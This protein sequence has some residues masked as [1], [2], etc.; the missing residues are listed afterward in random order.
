MFFPVGSFPGAPR[1]ETRKAL[2]LIDLQNDFV[3]SN[4]KLHVKNVADFLPRLPGLVSKFRES[5]DVIWIQT[6]FMAPRPTIS[7]ELGS[8]TIVLKD[9]VAA[10]EDDNLDDQTPPVCDD[11]PLDVDA[12][13]GDPEA[14]LAPRSFDQTNIARCCIAGTSGS[15]LSESLASSIDDEKDVILIKSHYSAFTGSPFLLNLR[16]KFV[17]ELYLCGSLSNISVYATALDAV[18]HGLSV[19]IIEDCV[20]YRNEACHKEAMRQMADAMGAEGVELQELVDDLN[21]DLGDVVTEDT[22]PTRFEVRLSD[23]KRSS[24]G[25]QLS[26]KVKEWMS[27]VDTPPSTNDHPVI[28]SVENGSDRTTRT[29]LPSLERPSTPND[30]A[31]APNIGNQSQFATETLTTKAEALREGTPTSLSPPRKRST[32]L[33]FEQQESKAMY[34]SSRHRVPEEPVVPT[35]KH[36][37][38][39]TARVRVRRRKP[40]GEIAAPRAPEVSAPSAPF[41]ENGGGPGLGVSTGHNSTPP[42]DSIDDPAV[43]A[44]APIQT[45][46]MPS[47]DTAGATVLA[48][49][50]TEKDIP[51]TPQPATRASSLG[52]LQVGALESFVPENQH[53]GAIN[54]AT[55]SIGEG[56]SRICHNILSPQHATEAFHTLRSAVQWQKM[57]H[58]SGEVP[59]LVAVQGEIHQDGSIPIYRHPADESPQLRP[60]CPTVQKLREY[61]EDMLQHPVNHVLIQLYRSG[62]DNISEHSDKTLDI[63]RGSDIV[64]LSLG[65]QR[66]MV[67]RTKKSSESASTSS[68]QP[69]FAQRIPLPHNSLFILGQKT[70]QHWLHAIRADKRRAA[71]KSTEE[72]DF[73]GERISLTF[74]YVGTFIN[75]ADDTIWGQGASEKEKQMAKKILSGAEA[76]RAGEAMIRA[77]GLENH[78]SRGFDWDVNYGK[79]FDV[80]NFVTKT[81][82]GGVL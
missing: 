7:P 21:G 5:G 17:S 57:Y 34:A 8:Y 52:A 41:P 79:G 63:V 4:G 23:L 45:Q 51:A 36:Q 15:R 37:K 22:F 9:F 27:D 26:P 48:I 72:L 2:V 35:S 29:S 77:F 39:N 11:A 80:V 58:R 6:H 18:R 56:D 53:A 82:S 47:L 16:K 75:P 1:L 73:G 13:A 65:A 64:N 66:T 20:G 68:G 71:E 40:K 76:E 30:H 10:A 50:S 44:N 60:F 46:S 24:D 55:A 74:R 49:Q 32:D 28:E 42:Q 25:S 78:Q 54:P 61:I 19:T 38:P 67:L 3:K 81:A 62:E 33:D 70:N 12:G 59:R 14:F 69:R 43:E 31:T